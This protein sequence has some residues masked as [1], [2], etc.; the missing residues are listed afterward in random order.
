M[1]RA[2]AEKLSLLFLKMIAD[3]GQSVRYVRDHDSTEAFEA[4]R[5]VAGTL[6]GNLVCDASQPLLERF[7]ELVPDY[8]GGPY[9]VSEDAYHP[10][11]YDCQEEPVIP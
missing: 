4:Y 10:L 5:K 8:L 7:P 3:L 11:F 1:T 6:M 9:K 2:E